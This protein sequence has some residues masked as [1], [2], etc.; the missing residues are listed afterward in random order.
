MRLPLDYLVSKL[1]MTGVMS[2]I[3]AVI[4]ELWRSKLVFLSL[5]FS[6]VF[7]GWSRVE[8]LIGCVLTC[9]LKFKL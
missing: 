7:D 1:R 8:F 4:I 5:L 2:S 6:P 3:F 9:L